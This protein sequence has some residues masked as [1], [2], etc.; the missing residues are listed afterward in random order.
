MTRSEVRGLSPSHGME[1]GSNTPFG[2]TCLVNQGGS[3]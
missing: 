3:G 2:M 1:P